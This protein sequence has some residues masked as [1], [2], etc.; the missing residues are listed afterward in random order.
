MC[1]KYF[2]KYVCEKCNKT[3]IIKKMYQP[4]K[5]DKYKHHIICKKCIGDTKI[6]S[7]T[8]CEK[9]FLL[10]FADIS[11]LKILYIENPNNEN[12][13][14]LHKEIKKII[15]QKFGSIKKLDK[16]LKLKSDK[17]LEFNSKKNS[18]MEKREQELISILQDNKLEYKKYGNCYS[19]VLYGKPDI[20]TIIEAELR[21]LNDRTIK[22]LEL[23]RELSKVNLKLDESLTS[24]KN[25]LDNV[26]YKSLKETIRDIEIEHFFKY[27]T[28][29]LILLDDYDEDV[30]KDIAMKNF[31]NQNHNINKVNKIKNSSNLSLKFD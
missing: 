16:I 29:Y 19:Y 28:D 11:H 5:I 8:E 4:R 31:L 2:L 10:K 17:K 6:Y 21:K 14:Y 22:K 26:G 30:A 20:S 3:I 13:Y 18:E 7:R 24:C 1:E 23:A 9:Y 12:K 27:N 25:Y 15:I